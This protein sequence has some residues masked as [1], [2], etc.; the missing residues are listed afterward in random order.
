MY[1]SQGQNSHLLNWGK[2]QVFFEE[3]LHS[4]MDPTDSK[5]FFV[6]VF[7]PPPTKTQFW[8]ILYTFFVLKFPSMTS[9]MESVTEVKFLTC[10]WEAY[11]LVLFRIEMP[12]LHEQPR[13][14]NTK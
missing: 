3:S 10:Q 7:F 5:F 6:L 9:N 14:N 13:H 1:C 11:L 4:T 12:P 2:E 8:M